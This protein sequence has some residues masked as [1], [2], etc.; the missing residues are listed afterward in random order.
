M[1]MRVQNTISVLIP[2]DMA[3]FLTSVRQS[4]LS[5][6][7]TQSIPQ[8]YLRA[9]HAHQLTLNSLLPHLDPP[10]SS[11]KSQVPLIVV[12]TPGDE[13]V[14][15]L[16]L[17]GRFLKGAD[18]RRSS[19]YVPQHFPDLPSRHTYKA[20]AEFSTRE[21]NPRKI[22]ERATEE[23][24]LGEEALRRLVGAGSMKRT[25]HDLFL[26]PDRKDIRRRREELWKETMEALTQDK[27]ES[28]NPG[29]LHNP[30]AMDVDDQSLGA[31]QKG[32]FLG[33]AVNADRNY[34]RKGSVA[35]PQSQARQADVSLAGHPK[36]TVQ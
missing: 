8:D 29:N 12:S 24:R 30:G 9:L 31:T 3:H 34:W 18:E 22:R 32:R 23:S 4:M 2:S 35:K 14:E 19:V 10:V 25:P 33:P 5:S 26:R 6:R 15:Q 1:N 7:R 21:Q 17:L 20:T 27:N 16:A 13:Q 36:S 28:L 11:I